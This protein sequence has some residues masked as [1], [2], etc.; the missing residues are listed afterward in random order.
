VRSNATEILDVSITFER[1]FG[2]ARA[3]GSLRSQVTTPPVRAVRFAQRLSPPVVLFWRVGARALVARFVSRARSC[4]R[5]RRLRG[6]GGAP[7]FAS[8][9]RSARGCRLAS[10]A[11]AALRCRAVVTARGP[12]AREFYCGTCGFYGELRTLRLAPARVNSP[13]SGA[14]AV[15]RGAFSETHAV[16]AESLWKRFGG[17]RHHTPPK[18]GLAGQPRG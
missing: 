4:A 10:L 11:V 12:S 1:K 9:P 2:R 6:S 13:C 17:V 14:V 8:S 15:Q 7:R 16:D 18:K 3:S 5:L